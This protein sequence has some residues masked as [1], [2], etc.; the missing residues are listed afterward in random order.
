MI[1]TIYEHSVDLEILEKG[2]WVLDLGCGVDFLF[3]KAML[4]KG[5]KVLAVD[6]NPKISQIPDHPNFYFVNKAITTEESKEPLEFT[7]YNDSDAFSSVNT[8]HDVSFVEKQGNIMIETV[9]LNDLKDEF[10]IN[11]IELIKIDIEGAEYGLLESLHHPISRQISIEYHDFRG[12]N[13]YFP[14]N[15][16]YHDKLKIKLGFY[17]FVKYSIEQHKGISGE[18]GLNYWD[19]LLVQKN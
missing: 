14:N 11:S 3:S 13:P 2:G 7:I 15:Q 1:T 9:T 19:C 8:M 17:N 18:Q 10:S 16:L 6:P 12:M 4:E 5:M